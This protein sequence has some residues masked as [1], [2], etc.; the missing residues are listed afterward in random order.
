M[1]VLVWVRVD[2]YTGCVT[3]VAAPTGA[4]V[5][6]L[7]WVPVTVVKARLVTGAGAS[8]ATMKVKG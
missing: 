4:A 3:V 8:L 2:V 5:D 7:V 1:I 6:V